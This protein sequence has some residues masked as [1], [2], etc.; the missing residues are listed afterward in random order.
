[1]PKFNAHTSAEEAVAAFESD[2]RGKNGARPF[3][4]HYL[5]FNPPR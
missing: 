3:G 1:M 4:V 5:S 2:I